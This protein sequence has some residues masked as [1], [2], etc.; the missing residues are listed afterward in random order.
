MNGFL[1]LVSLGGLIMI[2]LLAGGGA[3]GKGELLVGHE[4]VFLLLALVFGFMIIFTWTPFLGEIVCRPIT[5]ALE[6][7]PDAEEMTFL[8]FLAQGFLKRKWRRFGIFFCCWE[9]LIHPGWPTPCYAA[10]KNSQPGSWLE[11]WFADRV[12]NGRNAHFCLEARQTLERR[13]LKVGSHSDPEVARLMASWDR[14]TSTE[15]REPI[16]LEKH[17]NRPPVRDDRIALFESGDTA[18]PGR[19]RVAPPTAPMSVRVH[20]DD[21][22]DDDCV[23][24]ELLAED[25]ADP[26]EGAVSRGVRA[27]D[28]RRPDARVEPLRALMERDGG[29]HVSLP[30]PTAVLRWV[31]ESV[32]NRLIRSVDVSAASSEEKRKK[33]KA[34]RP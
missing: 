31:L 7:E 23:V 16:S 19:T 26:A 3:S 21:E 2:F 33:K 11:L 4:L 17:V 29:V 30:T 28:V 15:K 18:G 20:E 32:S 12:W 27:T 5:Q 14:E 24:A 22:L 25:F 13:G 6:G 34:G 10:M 8:L 9:A 1:R